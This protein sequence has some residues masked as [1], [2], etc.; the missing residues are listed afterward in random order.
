MQSQDNPGLSAL[1]GWPLSQRSLRLVKMSSP[2]GR[3]Q[4][5]N[6]DFSTLGLKE[7]TSWDRRK[8]WP[9]S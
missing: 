2:A 3:F 5:L 4:M 8:A 1:K 9:G 7:V 6:Y